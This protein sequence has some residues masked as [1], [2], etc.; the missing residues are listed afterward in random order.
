MQRVTRRCFLVGAHCV[1]A[2]LT[3]KT[4]EAAPLPP[5]EDLRIAMLN[6]F[7]ILDTERDDSVFDAITKTLASVLQVD[8]SMV[9]LIDSH[10]QWSKSTFGTN[11]PMIPLYWS[12][13]EWAINNHSKPG[14]HQPPVCVVED[15]HLDARFAGS[16]LV[17]QVPSIRFYAGVPLVAANNTRL[18]TLCV[19]HREPRKLAPHEEHLLRALAG[20]AMAEMELRRRRH[21]LEGAVDCLTSAGGGGVG[22]GVSG[23]GGVGGGGGGAASSGRLGER[24]DD[25]SPMDRRKALQVL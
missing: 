1:R 22:V 3:T 12:V 23:D 16:P 20:M 4:A 18:G 13:C 17:Q 15:A 19:L 6:S 21:T 9:T 8:Y 24:L 5:D 25:L 2:L 10:R 11:A 7:R 14:E